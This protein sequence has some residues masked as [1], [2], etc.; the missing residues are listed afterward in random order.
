MSNLVF[1][2]KQKKKSHQ[3]GIFECA[4]REVKVKYNGAPNDSDVQKYF[5]ILSSSILNDTCCLTLPHRVTTLNSWS[6]KF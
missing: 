4:Q 2:N 3:F 6:L 5:R 1:W